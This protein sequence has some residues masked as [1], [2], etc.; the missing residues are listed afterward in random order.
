MLGG[1][2]KLNEEQREWEIIKAN[3]LKLKPKPLV[4]T[5]ITILIIRFYL[6]LLNF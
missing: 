1:L 5:N 2:D 6:F 3:I 4:E